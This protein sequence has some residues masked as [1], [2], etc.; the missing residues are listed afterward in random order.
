MATVWHLG[1]CSSA[2]VID[3]YNETNEPLA[4]TTIRT[5]LANLREKGYLE[6]VATTER[7]FRLRATVSRNDFAARTLRQITR[8]LLDGSPRRAIACLIND[9]DINEADLEAIQALI[10][11]RKKRG[12]Q[13]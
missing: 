9:H 4:K 1:E 2:E 13:P 12:N 10:K 5:V 3:A 6:P 8:R 11:E 7:G